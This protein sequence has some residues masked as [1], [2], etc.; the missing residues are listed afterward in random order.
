MKG[1]TKCPKHFRKLTILS[2]MKYG[3]SNLHV[4]YF[5]HVK[6]H[7]KYQKVLVVTQWGVYY[8][9]IGE[10]VISTLEK[11]IL[12]SFDFGIVLKCEELIFRCTNK[13][14]LLSCLIVMSKLKRT[15]FPVYLSSD[16][17]I[18][19]FTIIHSTNF[20]DEIQNTVIWKI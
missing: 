19:F 13:R 8:I 3:L 14:T 17:A 9:R 1:G 11:S 6:N 2:L 16:I 12:H 5:F 7:S 15:V 18:S 4:N 20:E 10:S